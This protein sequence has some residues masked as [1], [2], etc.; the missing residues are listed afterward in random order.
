[1]EL[2]ISPLVTSDTPSHLVLQAVEAA[3]TGKMPVDGIVCG[4]TNS[5]MGAVAGIEAAGRK[6]G[7]E[8]DVV[9]KE[10]IPFLQ[11]FRPE[12]IVVEEDVAAAGEALAKAAVQANEKPDA[13][14]VQILFRP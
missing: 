11:L 10:A 3:A 14:P 12:M 8:V 9:A 7:R 1:M 13:P 6:L 5:A 2:T 4:S